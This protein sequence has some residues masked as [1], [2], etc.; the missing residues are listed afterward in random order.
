MRWAFSFMGNL[1][2]VLR[3]VG[4]I[5]CTMPPRSRQPLYRHR[6]RPK[7]GVSPLRHRRTRKKEAKALSAFRLTSPR[8]ACFIDG[9]NRCRGQRP[10][11]LNLQGYAAQRWFDP[12]RSASVIAHGRRTHSAM[13][14]VVSTLRRHPGVHLSCR[15]PAVLLPVRAVFRPHAEIS[16]RPSLSFTQ[17]RARNTPPQPLPHAAFGASSQ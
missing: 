9:A 3:P 12:V 11:S 15:Q 6:R 17:R 14:A 7:C 4:T 1:R 5:A 10:G 13:D 16:P 2:P 8:P